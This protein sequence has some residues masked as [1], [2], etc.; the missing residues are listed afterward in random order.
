MPPLACLPPQP[1]GFRGR[2][3][4]PLFAA[5]ANVA[6]VRVDDEHEDPGLLPLGKALYFDNERMYSHLGI[7]EI[8]QP[9]KLRSLSTIER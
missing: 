2:P 1:R 6:P 3:I 8:S 5:T 7:P 4:F 9:R